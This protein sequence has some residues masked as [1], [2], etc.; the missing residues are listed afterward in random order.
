MK[1]IVEETSDK[2]VEF[3][4]VGDLVNKLT[5]DTSDNILPFDEVKYDKHLNLKITNFFGK[6]GDI[7]K[8]I[9]KTE[10][11]PAINSIKYGLNNQPGKTNR[12]VKDDVTRA[13]TDL[14][15]VK[16][17]GKRKRSLSPVNNK[18]LNSFIKPKLKK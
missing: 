5:N 3:Y 15:E 10:T 4:R 2:D 13:S 17:P 8:L 7:P 6:S 14:S 9:P 1:V 18:T 16:K 11:K 12:E